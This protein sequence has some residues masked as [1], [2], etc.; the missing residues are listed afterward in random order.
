MC[1]IKLILLN[2]FHK[3]CNIILVYRLSP[4]NQLIFDIP[5]AYS[6]FLHIVTQI[7]LKKV[8]M[9]Y[10]IGPYNKLYVYTNETEKVMTF[11]SGNLYLSIYHIIFNFIGA[12]EKTYK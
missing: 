11:I 8:F 12:F 10:Y 1:V 5:I 7:L 4:D 2:H 3:I 9:I 6:L